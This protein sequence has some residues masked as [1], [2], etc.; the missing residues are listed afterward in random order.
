MAVNHPLLVEAGYFAGD[1]FLNVPDHPPIEGAAPYPGPVSRGWEPVQV[2][3]LIEN[4]VQFVPLSVFN[5][6]IPFSTAAHFY[7]GEVEGE[8]TLAI[9]FRSTYEETNGQ[10]DPAKTELEF[11]FQG[12]TVAPGTYGWDLYQRAHE[13]AVRAALDQVEASREDEDPNNDIDQV[14]ITGHSLGGIIAEL[15]TA[16]VLEK[17]YPELLDDTITFTFGSP[18]STEDVAEANIVNLI[19]TDDLVA[20]LS[21]LSP[22]FQAGNVGREGQTLALSRPEGGPLTVTPEDLSTQEGILA[23]LSDRDNRV[24]HNSL[25]YL[26]SILALDADEAVVPDVATALD[27]P[28]RWLDLDIER[29]RIGT[30]SGDTYDGTS[31]ADLHLG[32]GGNDVAHGRSG[33]DG[34]AG[35][36]GNDRLYGDDGNDLLFG[37]AGKDRAYGGSGNDV[38][39]ASA[40]EDYVNGGSGKDAAVFLQ[41]VDEIEVRGNEIEVSGEGYATTLRSVERLVLDGGIYAARPQGLQTLGPAS[42]LDSWTGCTDL[43]G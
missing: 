1:T 14:M 17:D 23:A 37:G 8:R 35:D 29:G 24:E 4:G 18:G 9:A 28:F 26:D 2:A 39:F 13:A 15:Q 34:L 41:P 33:D 6:D 38:V 43:I 22:I 20:R 30:S 12:S 36:E 5:P 42:N 40:G 7:T 10:F 11:A 32:R 16:R 21:D 27:D 31:R 3:G 19:H 25:I